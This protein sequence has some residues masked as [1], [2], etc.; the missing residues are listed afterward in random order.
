M[1]LTNYIEDIHMKIRNIATALVLAALTAGSASA[2]SLD[3]QGNVSYHQTGSTIT[4]TGW[5]EDSSDRYKVEQAAA[6]IEGV[7]RV[8]N[9]IAE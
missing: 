7:D 1:V 4:I 9:L 6:E 3:G 2:A 5:V 8:I